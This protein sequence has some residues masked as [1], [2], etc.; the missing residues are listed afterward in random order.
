MKPKPPTGKYLREWHQREKE[1]L[2]RFDWER[3]VQEQL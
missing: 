3:F 2:A 1:R